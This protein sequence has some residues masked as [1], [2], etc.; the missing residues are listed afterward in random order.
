M[1]S[2]TLIQEPSLDSN[3]YFNVEPCPK[4]FNPKWMSNLDDYISI[5]NVSLPGTHDTCAVFDSFYKLKCQTWGLKDQLNAGIR[6]LDTRCRHVKD[7]F[8]IYH[9]DCYEHISFGEVLSIIAEFLDNNPFEWILLRIKEESTPIDPQD[10][11]ANIA[12]KYIKE[13][14]TYFHLSPEIPKVKVLRGKIFWLQEKYNIG[15]YD[16]AD[17]NLQDDFNFQSLDRLKEK[18]AKVSKHLED[19]ISNKDDKLYINHLSGSGY[20]N[21]IYPFTVAMS[22]NQSIFETEISGQQNMGV[23]VMD[24][25]GEELILKIINSNFASPLLEN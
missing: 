6:Y 19:S 9:S 14:E 11:F 10:T 4:T 1:Q 17:V 15:A 8:L 12:N 18:T 20:K 7:S 21:K 2:T 13:Y 5:S 24:F 25:P 22:S 16:W 23:I 3:E